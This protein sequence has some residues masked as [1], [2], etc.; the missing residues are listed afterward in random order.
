MMAMVSESFPSRV[1][2]CS[3][4]LLARFIVKVVL[5]IRSTICPFYCTS[6]PSASLYSGSR[7]SFQQITRFL[8]LR[9]VLVSSILPHA[10]Y[11][12]CPHCN[13]CGE[14]V[15][16]DDA[17]SKNGITNEKKS[18]R[19]YLYRKPVSICLSSSGSPIRLITA[20]VVRRNLRM[21]TMPS[22]L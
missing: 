3:V 11:E 22:F 14:N 6:S 2:L 10:V 15:I 1:H 4:L 7:S 8:L 9:L 13:C 5:F 17:T 21:Q 18:N 20:L 12:E 16:R 19:W